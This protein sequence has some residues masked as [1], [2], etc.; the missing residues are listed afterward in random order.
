MGEEA[1][2][3]LPRP[4]LRWRGGH[5][6][7][8]ER[9]WL[10]RLVTRSKESNG[11]A[12][13]RGQ[14]RD[15][16]RSESVATSGGADP[17]LSEGSAGRM[18]TCSRAICNRCSSGRPIPMGLSLSQSAGTRKMVIYAGD[19][20]LNLSILL[21]EGN[22]T[23]WYFFSSGERTRKRPRLNLWIFGSPNCSLMQPFFLIWSLI[24]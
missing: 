22:E 13:I 5:T 21:S 4:C 24:K 6:E 8:H 11:L 19:Y 20:S 14:K 10:P 12:R 1:L 9:R 3:E 18:R 16:N 17:P 2:P 7:A 15:P 23:N